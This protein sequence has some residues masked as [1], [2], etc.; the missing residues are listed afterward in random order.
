M[1]DPKKQ[2]YMLQCYTCYNVTESA[3]ESVGRG[4]PRNLIG[5]GIKYRGVFGKI[6]SPSNYWNINGKTS[7]GNLSE[8]CHVNKI[9]V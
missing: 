8:L 6:S 5:F 1:I 2:A 7:D 4:S 3:S 9:K